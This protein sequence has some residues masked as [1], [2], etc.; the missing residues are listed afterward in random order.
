MFISITVSS[1]LKWSKINTVM[2]KYLESNIFVS[3][4]VQLCIHKFV[5]IFL[6][7]V[8]HNGYITIVKGYFLQE[9][10]LIDF[11]KPK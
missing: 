8:D 4:C 6:L 5:T 7:I 10:I 2:G 11:F 1:Y 9:R 3:A